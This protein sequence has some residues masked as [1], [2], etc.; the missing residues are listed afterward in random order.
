MFTGKGSYGKVILV[1]KRDGL[2]IGECYAMKVL[3]KRHV[4]QKRQVEHTKTERNVL[5]S[6]KHPFI[7]KLH[8]AFQTG[9]KLHF[10]LDYASGGELFFHLQKHGRFPPKLALFYTAELTMAFGELHSR[11][12]VFRDLKPEN[13]LIGG[14]GHVLLADFGLSKGGVPEPE[15]GTKSFCGTPEYLA[16]E[17]VSRDPKGHG[18][19][20]DW[21]SLGMLVYEMLTG[22]PPWYTKDRRELFRR[23]QKAPLVFPLHVSRRAQSLI[24]GLLTRD[25]NYRLGATIGKRKTIKNDRGPLSPGDYGSVSQEGKTYISDADTQGVQALKNH[26]FFKSVDWHLLQVRKLSPPFAPKTRQATAV[27]KST[28]QN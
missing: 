19:A 25:P 23:I 1:R 10:V 24:K 18:T 14:D 26:P 15:R 11:A 22:L 4:H 8:Y 17:I 20:V 13:V 12:V 27:G 28:F 16:P 6:I 21:W 7:V 3:K 9:D 2:D 5:A